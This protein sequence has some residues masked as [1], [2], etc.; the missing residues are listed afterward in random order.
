MINNAYSRTGGSLP[1]DS[2]VRSTNEFQRD[3]VKSH[4][5]VFEMFVINLT[6]SVE[7]NE[8]YLL[9]CI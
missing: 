1:V 3:W 9:L 2:F 8:E 7:M 6:L 4:Y 5:K